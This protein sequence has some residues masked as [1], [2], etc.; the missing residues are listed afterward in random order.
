MN[1]PAHLP[2][3]GPLDR[4]TWLKV[5]RLSLGA[6]AGGS[7][8]SMAQLLAAT[9]SSSAKSPVSS[10]AGDDFSVILFWAN[11]G[12]SHLDIFD[13]KPDGMSV[14]NAVGFS[15]CHFRTSA[16]AWLR[17]ANHSFPPSPNSKPPN[18]SNRRLQCIKM[19]KHW[20]R[21]GSLSILNM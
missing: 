8:L 3:P 7:A 21:H 11:G 6:S 9:Q 13:L 17:P 2:C 18:S 15:V 16:T 5:G 4:R 14:N 20:E 19:M 12:P 1:L 10:A